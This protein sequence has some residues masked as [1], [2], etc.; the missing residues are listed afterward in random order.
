M[1]FDHHGI[2]RP[3]KTAPRQSLENSKLRSLAIHFDDEIHVGA[4]SAFGKRPDDAGR[5]LDMDCLRP[6]PSGRL[7]KKQKKP[8]ARA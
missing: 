5:F 4:S 1:P 7:S 3:E 8:I 6:A 2:D